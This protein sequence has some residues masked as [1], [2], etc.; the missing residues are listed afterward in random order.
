MVVMSNPSDEEITGYLE[1]HRQGTKCDSEGAFTIDIQRAT[2]TA[3]VG[4]DETIPVLKVFQAAVLLAAKE[5]RFLMGQADIQLTFECENS[6]EE[7]EPHTLA[8]SL[9]HDTS[10]EPAVAL[11]KG[12]LRHWLATPEVGFSWSFFLGTSMSSLNGFKK[13]PVVMKS[14]QEKQWH[15]PTYQMQLG[16]RA[17]LSGWGFGYRC[18]ELISFR[19]RYSRVRAEGTIRSSPGWEPAPNHAWH[20]EWTEGYPLLEVFQADAHSTLRCD[21]PKKSN[22]RS[23]DGLWVRKTTMEP[24][25]RGWLLVFQGIDERPLE[26]TRD[27]LYCRRYASLPIAL[28]GPDRVILVKSGVTLDELLLDGEGS[29]MTIVA[30]AQGISVDASLEQL[31]AELDSLRKT[32]WERALMEIGTVP[33][34][35]PLVSLPHP[36]RRFALQGL[37]S[38][39]RP[40]P[41]AD[42]SDKVSQTVAARLRDLI[43]RPTGPESKT[44]H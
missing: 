18:G 4:I 3:A 12:A 22:Y 11:I 34:V 30:E 8:S 24:T 15:T 1:R 41:R 43:S 39:R 25:A 29:G 10:Q 40:K 38:L 37:W 2:T 35:P 7:L 27:F 5:V 23:A 31:L 28:G 42:V 13:Q 19:T 16:S 6:L 21:L 33:L 26:P 14:E 9:M 20:R 44:S 32:I 36:L 17:T